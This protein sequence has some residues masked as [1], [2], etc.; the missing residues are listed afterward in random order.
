MMPETTSLALLLWCRVAG[1]GERISGL[2]WKLRPPTVLGVSMMLLSPNWPAGPVPRHCRTGCHQHTGSATHW[3]GSLGMN[4]MRCPMRCL[5]LSDKVSQS[6][7]GHGPAHTWQSGA[8]DQGLSSPHFAA[9]ASASA[10]VPWCHWPRPVLL[11]PLC[12]LSSA[13]GRQSWTKESSWRP[14]ASELG[15][16]HLGFS[17]CRSTWV[18]W[19]RP[20]C[21]MPRVIKQH[22][23]I[24]PHSVWKAMQVAFAR[25]GH[26]KHLWWEQE[27][28]LSHL[29]NACLNC[30]CCSQAFTIQGQYA[31]PHP[32]VSPAHVNYSL[33]APLPLICSGQHLLST[34]VSNKDTA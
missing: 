34:I 7:L 21:T 23:T 19:Q 30:V 3:H 29:T 33:F 9:L 31:I 27:C 22:K 24:K 18:A 1:F 14:R 11:D 20:F 17:A 10:Q 25:V 15:Q 16:W 6:W 8:G 28:C 4:S 13:P 26:E 32:D 2:L 12:V 5:W